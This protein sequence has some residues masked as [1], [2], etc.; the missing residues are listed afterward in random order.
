MQQA[1]GASRRDRARRDRGTRRVTWSRRRATGS[2]RRSHDAQA[3]VDAAVAAQL[4]LGAEPWD[5]TGPLRVRMGIH[6]G[7]AER[8]RRRL[9]RHR[10]EPGR[11]SDVDRAR[12][13]DRRVARDGGVSVRSMAAVELVDLGEHPL[14]DLARPERVFQVAHPGLVREFPR[15]CVAGCVRAGTC[16]CRSR[17]S[18]GATTSSIASWR[19]STS[20][21]LVTLDRYRWRRQDAPR[22]P[23]RS[24][25]GAALRRRCVVLRAGCGRRRRRDGAGR[26]GDAR[27][28]AAAGAVACREHRRVPQGPRAA[29]R[30]RQLR[31]PARRERASWPM[32]SS[33][34]CPNVRVLATS[35]EALDV[36]GE[37]VWCGCVHSTRPVVGEPAT[38]CGERGRAPVR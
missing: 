20:S 29:P 6:S 38:S 26:R 32:R 22:D 18:S 15:V 27:L 35:R 17:R 12:R 33:A 23:G 1:L 9:L 3:A 14:R 21:S 30:A 36:D 2:T 10:G 31:A 16:P 13:A 25:G 7:A 24:R 37:R 34:S 8:A 11:A 28:L 19:S 4:A 5:A